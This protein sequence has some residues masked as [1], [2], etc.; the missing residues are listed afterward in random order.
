MKKEMLLAMLWVSIASLF[1]PAQATTTGVC[2]VKYAPGETMILN[3]TAVNYTG[4]GDLPVYR[5]E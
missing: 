5:M 4:M 2:M 3:E 1:F